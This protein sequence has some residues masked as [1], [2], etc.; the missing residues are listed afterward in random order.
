ME[1][2]GR[3]VAVLTLLVGLCVGGGIGLGVGDDGLCVGE[4]VG[5]GTVLELICVW[6]AVLAGFGVGGGVWV[7]IQV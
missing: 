5:L 3:W 1:L 6:V 4:C 7:L 2:I